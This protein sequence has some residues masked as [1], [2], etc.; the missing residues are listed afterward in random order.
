M[1]S[2]E[3]AFSGLQFSIQFGLSIIGTL[4][5]LFVNVSGIF[6]LS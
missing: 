2:G 1:G 6:F 5:G 4:K 3:G